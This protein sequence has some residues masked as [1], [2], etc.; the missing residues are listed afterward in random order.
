[1]ET[2]ILTPKQIDQAAAWI[3]KGELV[4]FP[5]ET[6]YGLGASIF[7]EEAMAKIFVAKGRPRD[8]PLIA[9]VASLE[10]VSQIAVD[11]PET[12]YLLA[13]RFFPGPLTLVVLRHPK[14]P[15]LASADLPTIALRQPSHPVAQEFI[16]AAGV[17]LVAPSANLSGNPSGT[18]AC[19]VLEDLRGK[20]AAIIDAGPCSIGIESTVLDLVSFERPTIL[21]P[22]Q[23]TKEQIEGVLGQEVVYY[24]KGRR[25]SPGM[26]YRHYAPQAIVKLFFE[27]EKLRAYLESAFPCRRLVLSQDKI[28]G[29]FLHLPLSAQTLYASLRKGDEER[30]EE[31]LL[32]CSKAIL[33]DV[34]LMNRI[35]KMAEG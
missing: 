21:R 10:A 17:P 23:I 9:H 33:A 19:H 12:F 7:N 8:N 11:L 26:R 27:E 24:S 28:E 6:V 3:K 5:T 34:G 25:A 1:V 30:C 2:E 20:I 31:L 4:A 15:A 14:V 32:L 35:T 29:P 16:K 22:G 13:R 18:T